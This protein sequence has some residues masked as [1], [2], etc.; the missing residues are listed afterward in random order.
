[1]HSTVLKE[2]WLN[3]HDESNINSKSVYGEGCEGPKTHKTSPNNGIN[4]L[5]FSQSRLENGGKS[6]LLIGLFYA[7]IQ[8]LII[9]NTIK[10]FIIVNNTIQNSKKTSSQVQRLNEYKTTEKC[11]CISTGRSISL[12]FTGIFS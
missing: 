10:H 9:Y 3:V 8:L 6:P 4:L 11:T 12:L 2:N 5:C 1:M 7:F